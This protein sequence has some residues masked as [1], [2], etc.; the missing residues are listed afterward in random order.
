[1][2]KKIRKKYIELAEASKSSSLDTGSEGDSSG[3]EGLFGTKAKRAASSAPWAY[4]TSQ[5]KASGANASAGLMAAAGAMLLATP[6]EQARKRE[7]EQRFAGEAELMSAGSQ[8]P[9][10]Q[11]MKMGN[12]KVGPGA[13]RTHYAIHESS[14]AC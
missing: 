13:L 2:E 14:E 8:G 4:P 9:T 5:K 12:K 11:E 1:M 3:S 7:R 10:L 6:E